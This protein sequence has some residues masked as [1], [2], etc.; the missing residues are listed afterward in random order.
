MQSLVYVAVCGRAFF[1]P[2]MLEG[3]ERE[4]LLTWSN[5]NINYIMK[6]IYI[7]IYIYTYTVEYS[8]TW[9]YLTD[10]LGH[11]NLSYREVSFI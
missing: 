8:G 5:L 9:L 1:K 10:T 7:Y 2:T 11:E 6:A 4:L 3:K